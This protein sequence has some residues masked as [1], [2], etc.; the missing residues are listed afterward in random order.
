MTFGTQSPQSRLAFQSPTTAAGDELLAKVSQPPVRPNLTSLEVARLAT[1]R[2]VFVTIYSFLL[3]VLIVAYYGMIIAMIFELLRLGGFITR[4]LRPFSVAGVVNLLGAVVL[5]FLLTRLATHVGL[6]VVGLVTKR[7]DDVPETS[8]GI[9][10]PADRYPDLYALVAEIGTRVMSPTPDEI[11]LTHRPDCYAVELR[12]FAISPD[13]RLVLVIGMPQLEVMTQEELKVVMAHELAHF[14]GGDTRLSVF[15]FR[16]LESLRQ[17]QLEMSGRRWR[18]IDPVSWLSWFY[19]H[20]FLML[21]S[22]IRKHQEYRADGWSAAAYGGDFAAQT[23][24]KDWLLERQFDEALTRFRHTVPRTNQAQQF[25]VFRDF[26][27]HYQDLSPEGVE[28]LERRLAEEER[29]SFWDSHPTLPER[30]RNMRRYASLPLPEPVPAR[31]LLPD[32]DLLE[33]RFQ[34][35]WQKE[36]TSQKAHD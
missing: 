6:G 14:G 22:P 10:L 36:P 8:S 23:L 3:L 11:R 20:V 16:F 19:F 15:V 30:M 28:Y 34:L 17:A 25:N 1:S 33:A 26:A 7:Y 5:S 29:S 21:S 18:W 2:S 4:E 31:L 13:R 9:L 24:L 32:F 27:A 12:S 35:Q